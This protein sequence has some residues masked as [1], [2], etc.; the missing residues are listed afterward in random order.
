MRYLSA[1][2]FAVAANMDN[3]AI[4][5][6]YGIKNR[7]IHFKNNLLIAILTGCGTLFAL[8]AGS[9]LRSFLPL[10]MAE[11]LGCG[12]LILMGLWFSI[13]AF[14]RKN[15][16]AEKY[17]NA[18]AD[19]T[20]QTDETSCWTDKNPDEAEPE[21]MTVQETAALALTL[22]AN[23]LGFG[24]AA[25][26]AGLHVLSTALLTFLCSILFL[27]AGIRLGRRLSHTPLGQ[28]SDFVSGITILLLGL[29]GLF[30]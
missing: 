5:A 4:G 10:D 26:M 18:Q 24:A 11:Y 2:L 1:L 19:E 3:V 23:N 8:T 9:L 22:T 28:Y 17:E 29:Y 6:A 14:R 13:Q 27:S 7:T 15:S 30:F 25:C 21:N 20:A 16:A 12:I